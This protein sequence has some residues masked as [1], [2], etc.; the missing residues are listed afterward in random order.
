M[1]SFIPL[2]FLLNKKAVSMYTELSIVTVHTC[3]YLPTS[4]KDFLIYLIPLVFS[5]LIHFQGYLFD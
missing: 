1:H 2:M 4:N 3:S 5:M